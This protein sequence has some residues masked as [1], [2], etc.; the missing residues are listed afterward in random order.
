MK[1]NT[2]LID[3]DIVAMRVGF[4]I[5]KGKAK[6]GNLVVEPVHH[7]YYNINRTMESIFD[8]TG[9]DNY[10]VHMS[11][12]G[13][14]NFRFGIFPD[15]KSNREG[16]ERPF[17]LNALR[18]Y[19][20][21][22]YE[23]VIIEGQEADDS[24]SIEHYKRNNLGWD[25]D[26]RNSI[27]CSIDKDFNNVPGWHLNYVK[28]E[29]YYLTEEEALR[30]FYLQ[31]LTGDVADGIPRIKKGWRSRK[32]E[33]ALE[34][35]LSEMD[36]YRIVLDEIKELRKIDP[37]VVNELMGNVDILIQRARLVHLRR[38]EGE[39]WEPPLKGIMER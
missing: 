16:F 32:T 4:A 19:L 8:K 31:I 20:T 38:Y 15:Y 6:K 33:E 24:I 13:R 18:E 27:I 5:Q 30:N 23:A 14:G 36:M 39:M 34:K 26:I 29:I 21:K 7:G 22:K 25:Y 9:A 17:H 35:V 12:P 3:G 1:F 10:V 37:L 11:P 2:V 28:D